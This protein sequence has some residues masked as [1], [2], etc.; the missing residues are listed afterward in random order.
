M[1]EKKQ[2]SP[3]KGQTEL[4]ENEFRLLE[5]DEIECRVGQGGK[6]N[7]TWCSLLLYKDARCDMKR[8]DE[9]FGVFGWQREHQ[10]IGQNLYCT[11]KIYKD[12][13]G[14]VSKQDV[15][16]PSNTESVKG[17]ASDAFK[18]ACFN[19]GIGRELYTA[20]KIFVNLNP[21]YDYKDGR[22][23]TVFIVG[24]IGYSNRKVSELIILDQK[25]NIRYTYGLTTEQVQKWAEEQKKANTESSEAPKEQKKAASGNQPSISELK[26]YALPAIEQAMTTKE[27]HDIWDYYPKLQSDK[28]FVQKI[29]QRK[30][31]V[32]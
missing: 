11:V 1:A 4:K 7:M 2:E 18:R 17:N 8:L 32:A 21:N 15:G 26:A 30:N 25:K 13:V 10:L 22:L 23:T 16:T 20:P 24:H 12:G 28:E 5:A 6:Q 31:E 3:V 9:R 29:T 14:W 19:L 27:L